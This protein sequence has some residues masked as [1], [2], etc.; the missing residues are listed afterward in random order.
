MYFH[1]FI[2]LI[3]SLLSLAAPLTS[4]TNHLTSVLLNIAPASSSCANA[5]IAS[6]CRT[7]NQAARAIQ[8]S[9]DK[10][11]ITNINEKAALISLMAYE[12]GSFKYHENVF[13]GRPGQ[14]TRNMQMIGYNVLYAES[15]PGL[16][17]KLKRIA[18]ASSGIDAADLSV[19][20]MDAVRDLLTADDV[21]DFGSAAWFLSTQCD[22]IVR[23]ALQT[24]GVSGWMQYITQ[25]VGTAVADR[26]TMFDAA[27][28]ALGS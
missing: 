4:L 7:A 21:L 20:Q 27:L 1:P 3:F 12:T 22:S 11:N 6:Q 14:G 5:P 16:A 24:E 8:A 10:Y 9:F 2:M 26:Q 15:V 28:L 23:D 18:G 25:C 13:P 17:A 19:E